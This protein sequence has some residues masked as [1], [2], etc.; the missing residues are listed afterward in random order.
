MRTPAPENCGMQELGAPG[1]SA[2][3]PPAQRRRPEIFS[4]L[5]GYLWAAV[6]VRVRVMLGSGLWLWLLLGLGLVLGLGLGAST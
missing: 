5:V 1:N 6:I 4:V 3:F 2:G